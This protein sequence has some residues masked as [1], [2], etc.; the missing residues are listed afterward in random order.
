MPKVVAVA[1]EV[2]AGTV[3]VVSDGGG[4]QEMPRDMFQVIKNVAN[5]KT[6]KIKKRQMT[7]S[8]KQTCS[9]THSTKDA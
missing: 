2:V 8:K 6:T 7:K 1:T 9:H 5:T 3:V 4:D